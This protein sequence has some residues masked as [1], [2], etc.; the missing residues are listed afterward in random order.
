MRAGSF[1]TDRPED[2]PGVHALLP[3]AQRRRLREHYRR[4]AGRFAWSA[5]ER[6]LRSDTGGEVWRHPQAGTLGQPKTREELLIE[7][8]L[9]EEGRR[10]VSLPE[11]FPGQAEGFLPPD[12]EVD[13]LVVQLK[14]REPGSSRRPLAEPMRQIRKARHDAPGV[15]YVFS[16]EFNRAVQGRMGQKRYIERLHGRIRYFMSL[17][18]KL[19]FAKLYHLRRVG[20]VERLEP[21]L[22]ER[23]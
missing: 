6:V 21:L 11:N 17:D 18:E 23:R 2:M 4:M 1:N 14:Y 20:G 19:R 9:A 13:G 5:Y 10:V 7:R 8:L 15:I 12:V 16:E 22:T 3:G